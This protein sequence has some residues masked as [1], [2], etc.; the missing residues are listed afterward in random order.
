MMLFVLPLLFQIA[1]GTASTTQSVAGTER[2][3]AEAEAM[4]D[5]SGAIIN[6]GLASPNT[7]AQMLALR[8]IGRRQLPDLR[9]A[10][11]PFLTSPNASVR[12]EAAT[13]LGQMNAETDYASYLQQEKNGDVRA[14]LFESVGRIKAPPAGTEQLL[15]SGLTDADAASRLGAARGLESFARNGARTQRPDAATLS[16]IHAALRANSGMK[17]R[18]LLLLAMNSA[19][20]TDSAT[21]AVALRD[22]SALVR[23]LAVIGTHK[24]V[25]DKAPMVRYE[26]LRAANNCER[27][28]QLLNDANEMVQLAAIDMLG[29]KKCDATP[30]EAFVR[31]G[32]TWRVRAH[33]LV[34]LAKLSPDAA[35][36][37]L[38]T[39]AVSRL[40]HD[41]VYAATAARLLNDSSTLAVLAR[42]TQPNVAVEAMS[43]TTD[44]IFG[45]GANHAGL[46][47]AAA[48]KLKGKP[49]L[50]NLASQIISAIEQPG[51]MAKSSSA[52][53]R[54]ALLARLMEIYEAETA[55]VAKQYGAA[56][57]QDTTLMS[58][59]AKRIGDEIRKWGPGSTESALGN[60]PLQPAVEIA[61]NRG[62]TAIIAM[63]G[64]GNITLDLL[65]DE[66][67][68]TVTT[69]ASLADNGKYN[70]LTFHRIVP[71]FVLQG[72]SPGADEYDGQ[73]DQFMR[74]E[75]G[76]ISHARGTLGISTRG[77][78][79]G[80]GQIFINTVDNFRLDRQYTVFARI[81]SGM[82][83]VD[84]IQEGDVIESVKI[85][86]KK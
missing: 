15:V 20:D 61:R 19:R 6:V 46:L 53:A 73:T 28:K 5:G 63:K 64:L 71:N 66:A 16:A 83:I 54:N 44:A 51:V 42:D 13:A 14:A 59:N 11:L 85:I 27:A 22:T 25:D 18:E 41:R 70:G 58:D 76:R 80:D 39:F 77:Y 31:N 21:Y 55:T 67:P 10:V 82:H 62:A 4:R 47:L 30:L 57:S 49:E 29:D 32:K 48:N 8:A 9:D 33:S 81:T 75:V 38:H 35:K 34:A 43:T 84:K 72:G 2:T 50:V 45:L 3:I 78:D 26:A 65:F 37:E 36:S 1:Q 68:R 52:D 17:M 86:R 56:R 74:D 69:F 7:H 12:A 79:K 24:W 23:R 40:W 60:G